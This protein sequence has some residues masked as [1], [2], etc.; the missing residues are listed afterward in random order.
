I[1]IGPVNVSEVDNGTEEQVSHWEPT[2]Q[3]P[4]Y[5]RYRIGTYD[6]SDIEL[7]CLCKREFVKLNHST[8]I[9]VPSNLRAIKLGIMAVVYEDNVNFDEAGKCWGSAYSLLHSEI[10][11]QRGNAQR[12]PVAFS[13][14]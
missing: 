14:W 3:F 5:A 12:A 8:D 9:V 4:S 13:P 7:N 2:D 6:G 1:T 10:Q 11:H